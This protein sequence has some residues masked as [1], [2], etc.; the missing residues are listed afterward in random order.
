MLVWHFTC[1]C[2]C[3]HLYNVHVYTCTMVFRMQVMLVSLRAGGVGLNLIGGN[4]LF[5]LDMHWYVCWFS[6]IVFQPHLTT[7]CNKSSNS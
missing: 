3:I 6:Q 1:L 5:L 7:C 4:H 2:A